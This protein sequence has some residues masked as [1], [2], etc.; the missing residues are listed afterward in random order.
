MLRGFEGDGTDDLLSTPPA[1][2][3]LGFAMDGR[4][5]YGPYDSTTSLASGLDVCNGRWEEQADGNG[6]NNDDV[7]ND[8]NE[9]V[10]AYTYRATSSFPYLIGCWGPAGAPPDA[11]LGTTTTTEGAAPTTLS[12]NGHFA[13][14][15]VEGGFLLEVPEN[16]C[17][18][19]RLLNIDSG[20]C[21]ACRAGTYGKNAGLTGLECPG[22]SLRLTAPRTSTEA[23]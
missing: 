2:P 9:D 23:R 12:A 14:T 21:E 4:R 6:G 17:P 8:G 1:S 7:G 5:L 22:V 20:Q 10:F 13:Y 19:G 15:E 18:A 11:A 3:L 16:G